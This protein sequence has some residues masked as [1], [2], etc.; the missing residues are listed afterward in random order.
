MRPPSE[1]TPVKGTGQRWAGKAVVAT[2]G[3]EAKRC[4]VNQRYR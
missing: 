1:A 2:S 4:V 3:K